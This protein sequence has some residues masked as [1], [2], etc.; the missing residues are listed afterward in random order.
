MARQTAQIIQDGFDLYHLQF[1]MI[2]RRAKSR[3]ENCDWLGAQK[4]A[5]E[6]LDLYKTVIDQVVADIGLLLGEESKNETIWAKMKAIRGMISLSS[7]QTSYYV[8][9]YIKSLT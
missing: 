2:T 1:K 8:F 4:D 7:W 9:C 3:F 6:R 5:T